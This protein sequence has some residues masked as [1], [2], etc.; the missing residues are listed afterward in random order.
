MSLLIQAQTSE[1]DEEI[2]ECLDL[3]LRSARLGLVHESVEVNHITSYTRSWFAWANGVFAETILDI[4]KRKPHLIFT[5][6]KPY[7]V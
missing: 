2:T 6:A 7:Q 1:N 3:V 5:E 4:A